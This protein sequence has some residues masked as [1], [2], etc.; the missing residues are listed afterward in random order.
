MY[1]RYIQRKKMNV[2]YST[3]VKCVVE[4]AEKWIRE[5]QRERMK[6]ITHT[7]ETYRNR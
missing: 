5:E 7:E 3:F 6:E 2:I 4:N 1:K